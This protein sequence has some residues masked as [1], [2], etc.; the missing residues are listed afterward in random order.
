MNL[1]LTVIIASCLLTVSQTE[2][3]DVFDES[4]FS[5][6]DYGLY[7]AGK[8]NEFEKA[9][10][11]TQDGS[12][13]YD[14]AKPTLI[15]IHGWQ[16][17]TVV[18]Q[19]RESFYS[20]VNGRPNIDFADLWVDNGYNIGIMYWNQFADESEVK[21]AEAKIW[22]TKGD[23]AMRWLDSNGSYHY[24]D[25]SEPVPELLLE[26]YIWSMTGYSGSD[27]RIAGHSLGS[28]VA[29]RLTRLLQES[30]AAE[31][32]ADNLV[33]ERLTLLDA[34]F[35]NWPK[36]YLGWQWT[37]EESRELVQEMIE[38]EDTAIDSYRTSLVTSSI[39]VG[40]ENEDLHN[41]V[42]FSEQTTGYFDITEQTEKHIAA[43]WLYLWS[44]D[45]D[46]PDVTNNA[47][48]GISAKAD[49]ELVRQWMSS[50]YQISQSAGGSTK[51]PVDDAYRAYY[52]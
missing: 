5:E 50:D 33:P 4:V 26:D 7:W 51:D 8:D 9:G 35:S 3:G 21:D 11:D 13:F 31:E 16:S 32:I 46:S 37:G 39:F 1:K 41:Q 45:Y 28:Q 24:G 19:Y 43:V 34:F 52:R 14:P 47:L 49:N 36:S 30:A 12:E 20:D 18:D 48:S 42:A 25:V 15:Y 2:A 22:S 27:I 6:L 17:D 23:K 40:D 29:I 44:I 38:Q 10:V